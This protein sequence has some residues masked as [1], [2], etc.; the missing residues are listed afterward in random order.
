MIRLLIKKQKGVWVCLLSSGWLFWLWLIQRASSLHT[1]RPTRAWLPISITVVT[2]LFCSGASC[3]SS[4][5]ECCCLTQCFALPQFVW[6]INIPFAKERCQIHSRKEALTILFQSC[7]VC[8]VNEK[9]SGD[10]ISLILSNSISSP[11]CKEA[12]LFN[13]FGLLHCIISLS[14]HLGGSLAR[15]QSN[16]SFLVGPMCL[17]GAWESCAAFCRPQPIWCLWEWRYVCSRVGFR[18][19]FLLGLALVFFFFFPPNPV[20]SLSP[21]LNETI[22]KSCRPPSPFWN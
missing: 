21:L 6:T 22:R 14:F 7:G 12:F 9:E 19:L 17:G 18:D 4:T 11:L 1:P 5:C 2:V 16:W 13:S 3:V 20:G 10:K 8:E 15:K